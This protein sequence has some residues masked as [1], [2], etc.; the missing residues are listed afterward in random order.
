MTFNKSQR[1]CKIPKI[2]E[3]WKVI[4]LSNVVTNRHSFVWPSL[5]YN[6]TIKSKP[7]WQQKDTQHTPEFCELKITHQLL[8][9]GLKKNA[10]T[11]YTKSRYL[12]HPFLLGEKQVSRRATRYLNIRESSRMTIGGSGK[13]AGSTSYWDMHRALGACN[14]KSFF[15]KFPELNQMTFPSPASPEL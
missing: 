15:Q 2:S 8:S 10:S 11:R 1:T 5:P 7:K 13:D 3:L 14:D 4:S 6:R 9:F 12:C